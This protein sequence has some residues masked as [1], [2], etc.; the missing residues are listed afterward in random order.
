M[1]WDEELGLPV[2]VEHELLQLRLVELPGKLQVVGAGAELDLASSVPED[3][4]PVGPT[5]K[6]DQSALAALAVWDL[7]EHPHG[8]PSLAFRCRCRWMSLIRNLMW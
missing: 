7:L 1:G 6:P 5:L 2:L 4:E 3:A 8:R